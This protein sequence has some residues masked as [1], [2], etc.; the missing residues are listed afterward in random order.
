MKEKWLKWLDEEISC[1]FSYSD[2]LLVQL[3]DYT[4]ACIRLTWRIVTQV[5]P[6]QLEYHSSVLKDIHKNTG[7]HDSA[8]MRSVGHPP[9]AQTTDEISC[10]L[11]PGLM[12]GG[13]R[14]IR[15][16]EVL[17]KFEEDILM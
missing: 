13:G 17:C 3:S 8:E 7:H 14:V 4:M 2:H 16:G 11:W 1:K 12:D 15:A 9:N 5:P 6:M 10:Y